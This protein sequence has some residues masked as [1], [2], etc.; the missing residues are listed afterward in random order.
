[1][2]KL[3]EFPED[4]SPLRRLHVGGALVALSE[5]EMVKLLG[6]DTELWVQAI[7][8]GKALIRQEQAANRLAGDARSPARKGWCDG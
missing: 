2:A 4:G 7:A 6:R 8:R 5:R 3:A 1:M